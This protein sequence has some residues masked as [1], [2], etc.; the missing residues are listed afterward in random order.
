M[1]ENFTFFSVSN[2]LTHSPS[3][4]C[5]SA[6]YA[7]YRLL[8]IFS[9]SIVK[10]PGL[11]ICFSLISFFLLVYFISV[12]LSYECLPVRVSLRLANTIRKEFNNNNNNNNNTLFSV[13]HQQPDDQLQIQHK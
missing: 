10:M 4:R 1:G 13:L 12:V 3:A 11:F 7:I 9:K 6:T 5:V 8:D 2:I